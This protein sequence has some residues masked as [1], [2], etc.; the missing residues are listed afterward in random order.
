MSV[1]TNEKIKFDF[2]QQQK[3]GKNCLTSKKII[4]L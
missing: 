4:T 3:G 2:Q 1:K